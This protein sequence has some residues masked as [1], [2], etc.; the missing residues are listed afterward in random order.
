MV[1]VVVI[2]LLGVGGCAQ[3][4]SAQDV[5]RVTAVRA[6]V[7]AASDQKVTA[8]YTG[9]IQGAE[10]AIIYAKIAE[11]VQR[12]KVLE[13]EEVFPGRV[14]IEL[15]KYGPTSQYVQAR[16]ML[17]TSEKNFKK[18]ESLYQD[19]AVSESQLDG[20]R[21]EYEVNKAAFDAARK[22]VEIESPIAGHVTSID[23]TVGDFIA[24]GQ[25]LA[26]VALTDRLQV[27]LMVSP[28]DAELIKIGQRVPL[29]STDGIKGRGE[30]IAVASSADPVTRKVSVKVEMDNSA[31]ALKPGLF[32]RCEFTLRQFKGVVAIPRGAVIELS[33][34]DFVYVALNGKAAKRQV[35]LG[36]EM[37]GQVVV[38]S[39]LVTGDTLIVSGQSY[40]DDGFPVRLVSEGIGQ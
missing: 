38:D 37:D 18:M 16:S 12:I 17:A 30:V 2:T 19:G 34:V 27:T 21:T 33:G 3:Q 25:E 7:I 40:L 5:E 1:G 20:V 11:T 13:G 32:V 23:V 4:E 22:L 31:G 36:I 9:T 26:T 6:D 15:D 29:V 39:G 8:E 14:L 35:E 28:S 10:Q 24:V